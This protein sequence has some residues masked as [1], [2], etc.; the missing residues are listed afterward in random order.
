MKKQFLFKIFLA[1][2]I[3]TFGACDNKPIFYD[4][5]LEEKKLEP[6]IKGSPTNFVVFNGYM[7]VASGTEVYR[8][9]GTSDKGI[10][11]ETR[12]GAGNI[13]AIAAADKLYALCA[14]SSN[15][16]VLRVSDDGNKWN[17]AEGLGR[18][19]IINTVYAANGQLFIGTG[20]TGSYS[21]LLYGGDSTR[22]LAKTENKML[23]GAAY[24]DGFYYLST[25]DMIS[26]D[27]GCIY[28]IEESNLSSETTAQ[29]LDKSSNRPF[30]G[31][32]NTGNG[33]LAIIRSGALHAV[34]PDSVNQVSG[35]LVD[36]RLATG[37]LA[38]WENNGSRLLLAGRQD[39][40]SK[41][42]YSHGYIEVGID[43]D[44]A[45]IGNFDEPGKNDLSTMNK[46]DNGR[47][48][49]LIGKYS[50]NHIFQAPKDI[51]DNMTLFISTQKDGV[52][53]YRN[54]NGD[55]SWNAEN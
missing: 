55:W 46:G 27:G 30:V 5:S 14:G 20:K 29:L 17:N 16:K 42:G 50:I 18:N 15:R 21:I 6:K 8:Y 3:L 24:H 35:V 43:I 47:Y 38:V 26:E 19:L 22:E 13:F 11:E 51:D 31:I 2:V 33:V 36:N 45:I 23:N 44:G 48:G 12:P 41:S 37:A 52:W 40:I 39:S 4:I 49:S 7:Y 9:R 34:T 53:S 25:K 54:R 28:G 10:W 1:A 32:I